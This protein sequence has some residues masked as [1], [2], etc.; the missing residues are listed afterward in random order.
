MD[1]EYYDHTG[2]E[3]RAGPSRQPLWLEKVRRRSLGDV[4]LHESSQAGEL[5]RR[6]GARAF[7]V[8]RDIYAQPELVKPHTPQG[9]ALLAHEMT[10]VAEQTG[11]TPEAMPLLTPP[12]RH[13]SQ[14]MALQRQAVQR[15][16]E[17]ETSSEARAEAA[18][19][20]AMRQA[21]DGKDKKPPPDPEAV[22]NLVYDLMVREM[23]RDQDRGAFA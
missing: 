7:T 8:G 16:S 14:A 21:Q 11:V 15:A 18:E 13:S 2:E 9:A 17:G 12:A 20:E 3:K 5:A 23:M 10:H 19:A 22:A 6:L 1:D 4:R